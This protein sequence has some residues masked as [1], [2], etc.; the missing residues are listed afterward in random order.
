MNRR[1]CSIC[2]SKLESCCSNDSSRRS[3]SLARASNRSASA[4]LPSALSASARS[5]GG[6]GLDHPLTTGLAGLA[7]VV[8][9]QPQVADGLRDGLLRLCDVVREIPDELV[10]HL[11][12]VLGLVEERVHV[13]RTAGSCARGSRSVPCRCLPLL[14]RVRLSGC[15]VATSTPSPG[16]RWLPAPAA[17]PTSAATAPPRRPRRRTAPA[18]RS[19]RPA[20]TGQPEAAAL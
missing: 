1:C 8:L 10:E 19:R 7:R 5:R 17:D 9:H 20:R 16:F 11:L 15:P 14:R 4:A 18:G 3:A 13:A 2:G 6:L 12:R